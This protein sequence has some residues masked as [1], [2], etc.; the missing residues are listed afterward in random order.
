MPGLYFL[1]ILMLMGVFLGTYHKWDKLGEQI[2]KFFK[3]EG[4]NR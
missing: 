4:R 2:I 1:I 3:N